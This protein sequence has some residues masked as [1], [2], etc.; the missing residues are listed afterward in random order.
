MRVL[1]LVADSLR[2]DALGCYGSD[3]RTPTVDQLASGGA[4]FETVISSAP[5]TLP[6]LG[7]MLTGVWSHRLG[8]M[9]WEQPWPRG[10][11]TLFDAF[12]RKGIETASF[13]FEPD[14]LFSA[15]PEASVAGSSQDTDAML[16]WFRARR[17]GDYFA[18]VHYWWT[19]V[20]YV[21]RRLAL[22]TW[23][24]V[25]RQLLALLSAPDP[26]T[27][28]ANRL[29]IQGLYA[30]A[31]QEFS[32]V[33]LPPLLEAARADTVV[34][35]SDHGESWGERLSATDTLDDVF[36]LH[37]NHLHEEVLRVPWIL[38][39]PGLVPAVT[40]SGLARSVD[41]LPTLLEV[42]ALDHPSLRAPSGASHARS[43]RSLAAALGTGQLAGEHVAFSSRNH[44]FL[45]APALPSEP[46]SVYAEFACRSLYRKVLMD[47]R[48]AHAREY[49]L[50]AD[51]AETSSIRLPDDS[52]SALAAA[53][54]SEL[55]HAVVS[56]HHAEDSAR[57]GQRLKDLG[58]L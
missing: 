29:Q 23:N 47:V 5:W 13:V 24:Q 57:M 21:R 17:H 20:P 52:P 42:L 18:F 50:R 31:V 39:S 1:F 37:G 32:E 40:V 27:R 10:V 58:Y 26:A 53:L 16:A 43:G 35:V 46:S 12:R 2:A 56:P 15:C 49:D 25:C 28:L 30:V 9:K 34:L 55:P 38:H 14:H 51:P 45:D 41:V 6:S 7:A 22:A 19:H 36:D 44:D 54:R 33:W 4:R 3:L 8:L 48:G 11:P